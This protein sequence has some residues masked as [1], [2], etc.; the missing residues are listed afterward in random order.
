MRS[1]WWVFAIHTTPHNSFTWFCLV[2][3]FLTWQ[4]EITV[5]CCLVWVIRFFLDSF[6][7]DRAA[8]PHS[9]E[10]EQYWAWFESNWK[11]LKKIHLS[12]N[13]L[14]DAICNWTLQDAMIGKWF[15][16]L[17]HSWWYRW[18]SLER[19]LGSISLSQMRT[20]QINMCICETKL[21]AF[22]K[23]LLAVSDN[24]LQMFDKKNCKWLHES[25]T[26]VGLTF[27][28]IVCT[29]SYHSRHLG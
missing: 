13:R 5:R 21:P 24:S 23:N 15:S 22:D 8:S 14:F 3:E 16:Y 1:Q 19:T 26:I 4:T 25:S 6:Y 12:S 27:P 29:T 7:F 2:N 28:S 11:K 9:I 17:S 20:C 10:M 18:Y